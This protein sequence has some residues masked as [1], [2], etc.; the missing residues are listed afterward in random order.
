MN[1]PE[2]NDINK[3]RQL[4]QQGVNSLYEAGV[5]LVKMVKDD[6]KVID[7]ICELCP[8]IN[9]ETILRFL[10]IGRKEVHPRLFIGNGPGVRKLRR[11]PYEI[12]EK[13]INQSLEVLIH[14]DAGWE[15]LNIDIFN[16]TVDQADQ[17][18]GPEGIRSIPAQRAFL[19][20]RRLDRAS[21]PPRNNPPFRVLAKKVV[22]MAPV[23]LTKQDLRDI[24]K[25]M[26]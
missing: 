12:Q 6:P 11:L 8:E 23:T 2:N 7:R 20:S 22:F 26:D 24:L 1:I 10:R 21:L 16:L 9:E 14:T 19:E 4:V 17:V 18:F 25:Q 3:F 5:L 15:P 13:H